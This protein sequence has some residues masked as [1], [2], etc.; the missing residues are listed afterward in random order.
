MS[1]SFWMRRPSSSVLR[2]RAARRLAG[3]RKKG[4]DL[5][6]VAIEGRKIA[7][8]FWGEA[9]CRHLESF[10]DF[11][12][13]LPRG[14][15]YI[16]NGAVAHLTIG[17][18]EIDALVVGSDLY[19]VKV[20]IRP[21]SRDKWGKLKKL[22][23][24]GIGSILEL[25]QGRLSHNVMTMVTDRDH[26]LFPLPNEIRLQ[27]SCP[28]WATMCKHV[29]AVLYG[30]GARLDERPEL[31]FLLR[32]VDHEELI[33]S[34]IGA[35]VVASATTS[36]RRRIASEALAEVFG[37]DVEENPPL[38]RRATPPHSNEARREVGKRPG[39]KGIRRRPRKGPIPSALPTVSTPSA[40]KD[41]RVSGGM[42]K[43]L[44]QRLELTRSE[45]ALLLGVSVATII[46]W[47][48]KRGSLNLQS[49]TRRAWN[50]A[51]GLTLCQVWE[52][53]RRE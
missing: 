8:T 11:S 14:R 2:K 26:G 48:G 17:K 41:D 49:R 36:S 18:G 7:R 12:N 6:P 44:R 38:A 35:T 52:K 16:R 27:C 34:D 40:G 37:I 47:E 9:W 39:K 33:G 13:R 22:C 53:K 25:L 4:F 29:A 31:F 46:N 50:Q 45:F 30:V 28:D 42:V 24:G 51:R 21:L 15:S 1:Y 23:S 43:Q 32:G 5:Q 3:L 20:V 10:S 19:T